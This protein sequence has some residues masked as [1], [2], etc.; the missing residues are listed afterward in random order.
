[1][2]VCMCMYMYVCM[3]VCMFCVYVRV[4][5]HVCMMCMHICVFKEEINLW[6]NKLTILVVL[7]GSA[8]FQKVHFN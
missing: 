2:Y 6:L 5:A 7:M 8:V 4:C 3:C 1:M